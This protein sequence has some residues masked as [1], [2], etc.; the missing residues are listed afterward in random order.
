VIA[1]SAEEATEILMRD[2][3]YCKEEAENEEGWTRLPD[4]KP[5]TMHMG[6][7]SDIVESRTCGEWV[8][9]HGKG[10]LGSEDW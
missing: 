5:L 4:D 7:D 3:G 8:G 6:E 1:E 2:L 9:V 10:Y